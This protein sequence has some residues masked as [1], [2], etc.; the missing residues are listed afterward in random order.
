[1]ALTET[2]L[3]Y[4]RS[5]L[6]TEIDEGNLEDRHDRLGSVTAVALEVI[7]ERLAT[8][9]ANPTSFT[10]PGVYSETRN[11]ATVKALQDQVTRLKTEVEREVVPAGDTGSAGRLVRTDRAR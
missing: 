10:I 9:L 1:M 5:E 8:V 3:A 11:D 4:L 2:D 7:R 6:G